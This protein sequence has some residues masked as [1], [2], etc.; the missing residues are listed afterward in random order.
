MSTPSEVQALLRFLAQ[1]SKQP[2]AKAM[3][4]IKALQAAGI[5]T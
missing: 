3:G 4:Y 1:D 5:T 2:M